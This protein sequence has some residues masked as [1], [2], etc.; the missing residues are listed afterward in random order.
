MYYH[1]NITFRILVKIIQ[2]YGA[3][4]PELGIFPG[5]GA[6]IKNQKEQEL[7]LKFRTGARSIAIWAVAPVPDPFLDTNGF[8]K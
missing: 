8:A 6:Q 1:A 4:P 3:G 2:G 7:S 5:T